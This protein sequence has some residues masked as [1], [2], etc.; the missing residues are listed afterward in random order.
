MLKVAIF[1]VYAILF[2]V[3]QFDPSIEPPK[4]PYYQDLPAVVTWYDP[5]QGGINCNEDCTTVADGTKVTE[6]LYGVTAAC[7]RRLL[8]RIVKIEG[9][10]TFRCRDTGGMIEPTWSRHYQRWILYF[11]VMLH[12]NP[13]WNYWL[14][15]EWRVV[16]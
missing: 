13:E 4:Q 16:G 1:T 15:E 8:G 2:G 14:I 12:E 5:S 7:D 6:D 10:G 11:D 9:I 3:E